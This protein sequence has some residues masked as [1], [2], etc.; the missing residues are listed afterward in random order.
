MKSPTKSVRLGTLG[1][2]SAGDPYLL[3]TIHTNIMVWLDFF[4]QSVGL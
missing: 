3:R 1:R 4:L 2:P